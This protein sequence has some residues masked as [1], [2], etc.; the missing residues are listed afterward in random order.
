MLN[1][2]IQFQAIDV[3]YSGAE[4]DRPLVNASKPSDE[5]VEQ[6]IGVIAAA[7]RPLVL[8]GRGAAKPAT[9]AALLE[10]ADRLGAPVATSLRGRSLFHGEPAALGIFGGLAGELESGLIAESDCVIAFGAGLNKWTTMS[11]DLLLG[12][13]VIHCDIDASRLNQI[14][15]VDVGIVGD[16][17]QTAIALRLL[18]DR[19]ELP[20][21][22]FRARVIDELASASS[23]RATGPA[24]ESP[25]GLVPAL[26]YLE[27]V[28]PA[29]RLVVIDCGAFML[30]AL[31]EIT[32]S[33]PADFV[34][35][36]SFGSIGLGMDMRWGRPKVRAT[37]TVL[38]AGDGGFMLGGLAEFNTA[39]R[40]GHD[41]LVVVANN[42]SYAPEYFHLLGQG[43]DVTLSKFDW[44]E[45]APLAVA[46]GGEGVTVRTVADLERA[47]A[48]IANEQSRLLIDVVVDVPTRWSPANPAD[49]SDE[50]AR[51][52]RRGPV[53]RRCTSSPGRSAR[54]GGPSRAAA[55]PGCGRRSRRRV[56]ERDAGA[57][58][59]E[60]GRSRLR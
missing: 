6:A 31:K 35:T 27:Q 7:R 3:D 60:R 18:A 33:K 5:A 34:L 48:A 11:G 42:R 21:S 38:L 10:L 57:V 15:P 56:A 52:P 47:G 41:L 45:F 49:Q 37:M 44:P 30:D 58:D 12:T 43:L 46:L 50:R 2:P 54:R 55:W 1:F 51:R 28:L 23:V 36:S 19:A 25:I 4:I 22:G 32:I 17:E 26:R 13:R 16:A 14:T 40:H 53:R 39:V 9:R 24:A 8:A 59:V 20:G 29:D